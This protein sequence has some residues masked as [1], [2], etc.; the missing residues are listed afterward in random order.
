MKLPEKLEYNEADPC[1]VYDDDGREFCS[2]T[3]ESEAKEI[4]SRYNA[5]PL[6]EQM[7]EALRELANASHAL[8]NRLPASTD[9]YG[10]AP[11]AHSVS[12]K[13][14]N[15]RAALAAYEERGEEVSTDDYIDSIRR[16]EGQTLEEILR[17]RDELAAKLTTVYDLLAEAI[18]TSAQYDFRARAEFEIKQSSALLARVGKP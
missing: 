5:H 6:L 18:S 11:E 2:T 7:A 1:T 8:L 12:E 4:V 10:F 9:H 3:Y 16:G 15:A 13:I 17:E 14:D